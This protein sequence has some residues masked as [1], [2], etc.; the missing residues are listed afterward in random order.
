MQSDYARQYEN[1]WL[2]HWWWQSRKQ[3]VLGH[4]RRLNAQRPF[5]QILD[6]GCGNGLFFDDLSQ[7][8]A[9][10]GIEPDPSLVHDGP[11]RR[12]IEIR[13]FDSTYLPP[14]PFDLILMLDVLEHIEDHL[15]AAKHVR[16]I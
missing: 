7:F 15:A 2:H 1:L 9:V 3:F 16:A 10:Q 11:H 4:L 14:N 6:I 13:L 5:N 12:Q 8:G